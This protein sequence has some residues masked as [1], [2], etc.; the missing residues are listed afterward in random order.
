M[1]CNGLYISCGCSRPQ[2]RRLVLSLSRPMQSLLPF[3]LVALSL[4]AGTQSRTH[5]RRL[6]NAGH[7]RSLE[8]LELELPT[9]TT[10]LSANWNLDRSF[11]I[12]NETALAKRDNTKYVFMHHIVGNTQA[13]WTADIQAIGA[14]GVDAIALNIGGDTWQRTQIGYAYA[15]AQ[16]ISSPVKLFISFDFTTN[17]GCD[18]N[19]IVQRTLQFSSHPSQFK[20][21]GRA[22]ISSYE[23][24][25]L[26]DAGWRS[27]KDQTNGYIM[28]FI[29]GLEGNFGAW[30][31]FDSWYCWGCAWSQNN[32]DKNTADDY[33]YISQVGSKYATTVS[34]WFYTHLSDK[35]R[36]LRSDDWLLNNRW[37]Q[38]F[39]MRDQLTFVEMVTWNDFGES[40]Y[41]G[42]VTANQPTGTTWA[43]NFPHTAWMDM[44]AYYIQAFKT[45]V[46][47]T[48]TKDVIYF[49]AR[50]HPHDATATADPLPQPANY[51]WTSD[52]LWA[53]AFCSS[54]CTVTLKSGTSSSQTWTNLGAGVNLLQLPLAPGRVS[55]AMSKGSTT[56][57]S[58]SP[59]DFTYVSVPSL[60]NLNVYVGAASATS[61]ATTS[62]ATA[63]T[64]TSTSTTTTSTTSTATTTTATTTSTTTTTTTTTSTSTDTAA[65][66][67]ATVTWS[68]QGCYTDN[69]GS[70]TLRGI[71]IDSSTGNSISSCQS[72]CQVAGYLYA[73]VEYGS[74]CFC[75][76]AI[77][78]G[79]ST[80]DESHC[81][82]PC[83]GGAGKCGGF[84]A[85]NIYKAS[86]ASTATTTT[87][88]TSAAAATV[89]AGG[90]SWSSLGCYADSTNQRVLPAQVYEG[91]SNG[92]TSCL[93]SCA[94][95]GY[96]FGGVEFG[97][98]CFCGNAAPASSLIATSD[99]CNYACSAGSASGICGGANRIN[100]YSI[101]G[102]AAPIT[103]PPAGADTGSWT[104]LGCYPDS[105]SSR[106]VSALEVDSAS[107]NSIASCET[108]C[109]QA[110]FSYAAVEFG[111]QCFCGPSLLSGVS[112]VADSHC[113]YACPAGSGN[114]GGF[115][116]ASV[117][118]KPA[119]SSTSSVTT[120]GS[121]AW[122]HL[123]CYNDATN[124]R[125]L[126]YGAYDGPANSVSSCLT[127]CGGKGYV[128]GGLEFGQQCFCG[129]TFTSKTA[130]ASSNCQYH[131]S[132]DSAGLC[133]GF[134]Y[135]DV[136]Y[137]AS[138]L[139]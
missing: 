12:D 138:G 24:A 101:S 112:A 63:T 57:L 103:T 65:T 108:T 82:Y 80:W 10:K 96:S 36:I 85:I 113:S 72:Q 2:I 111:Q 31:S 132:G 105:P 58:A 56:V 130:T 59:T 8:E 74:Q 66:S 120:V 18:L 97:S 46:Y 125:V 89:T 136:Y 93:T 76:A 42:P 5:G 35:N 53:A 107:S 20:V 60:Y 52:Y 81:S 92:V 25:C 88:T 128:Y 68:Y 91:P 47:P 55:V 6:H 48:V 126:S 14:Q 94:N 32:Q 131:C 90:Q 127:G 110:G 95:A 70:R 122:T 69:G 44:S 98:Q 118:Y 119:S 133:G 29:S 50:P 22:M 84:N 102:G 109:S 114:C 134:N 77:A 64:S 99:S 87:T 15:A 37:N 115:N 124:A 129:S 139:H 26:G 61:T 104:Y 100:I 62:T 121:T 23:G 34:G 4:T 19:D 51:A 43:D 137:A 135:V 73:G 78:S 116:Y 13:N 28:P 30:S 33:Y 49:W 54:T 7:S 117:Y 3:L 45:G 86:S 21:N 40:D 123:G 27:L 17:L 41:F 79:V 1:Y 9:R 11:A 83:P 75:A 16:A 67:A 106:I 38:I 39:Q 71:E